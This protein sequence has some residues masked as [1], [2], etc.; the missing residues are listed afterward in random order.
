MNSTHTAQ[1][2][3]WAAPTL[4]LPLPDWL[5]AWDRPWSC[6]R[7]GPSRQ[8]ETTECCVTCPRWEERAQP[9]VAWI[10]SLVGL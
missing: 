5:D 3:R 6:R 8:L 9:G 4:F 2:C 10:V 7:D 1:N